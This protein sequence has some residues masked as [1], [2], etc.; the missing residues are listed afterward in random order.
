MCIKLHGYRLI[1]KMHSLSVLIALILTVVNGMKPSMAKSVN[2][3]INNPSNGRQ[4][5]KAPVNDC[6]CHCNLLQDSSLKYAIEALETKM[7]HL[8]AL[9]NKTSIPKSSSSG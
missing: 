2:N 7:E 3:Q 9:V 8:I 5:N 1:L 4:C 6:N